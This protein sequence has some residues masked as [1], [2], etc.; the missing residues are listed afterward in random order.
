MGVWVFK[1]SKRAC[2]YFQISLQ[3]L[4]RKSRIF[5]GKNF[6]PGGK[7]SHVQLKGFPV[8]SIERLK[9]NFEIEISEMKTFTWGATLMK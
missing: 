1:N 6:K 8:S 2:C 3:P 4:E 5:S 9:L 7:I